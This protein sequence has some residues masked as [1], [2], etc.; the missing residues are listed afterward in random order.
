MQSSTPHRRTPLLL[1]VLLVGGLAAA[2][3]TD[4][5]A[6]PEAPG[7]PPALETGTT[8]ETL[9]RW[10]RDRLGDAVIRGEGRTRQFSMAE[11]EAML[12]TDQSADRM[13][14]IIPIASAAELDAATLRTL[15][16]ANFD[17]ALDAKYAIHDDT[18]WATFVHPLGSLTEGE[19]DSALRQV[20]L[21]Y[22]TYGTAYSSLGMQFGTEDAPNSEEPGAPR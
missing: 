19:F 21:L 18:V 7:L 4:P 17:R 12:I 22:A 6:R 20:F 5:P 9:D 3:Q 13:R 10:L 16:E 2:K 15:L 11:V 8:V 1:L 14:M